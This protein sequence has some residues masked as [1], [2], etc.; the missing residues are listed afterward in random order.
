MGEPIPQV[1]GHYGKLCKTTKLI[2][3]PFWTK[4]RVGQRLGTMYYVLLDGGADRP[5]GSGNFRGLS[6]PFKSIGN[7][8]CRVRCER[9]R[10]IANNVMQQKGSFSMTGK[11]K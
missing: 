1:M 6:G 5:K 8:C 2:K 11:R 3:M 9:D 4:T 10:L 7:I